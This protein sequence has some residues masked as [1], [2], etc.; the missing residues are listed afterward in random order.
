M[1]TSAI[2]ESLLVSSH[3]LVRIAA[4]STGSTTPSAIWRTLSILES[5]GPLRIGELARISRVTQ[6]GM[7]RLL[8]TMVEEELVLRIADV[9]DSRA[10]LI[11]ITPKGAE[12][13]ADWRS[14]LTGEL[15]TLFGELPES[16]WQALARAAEL[17][18]SRTAAVAVA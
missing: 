5:E 12:R 6:P 4:Q 1:N 15:E 3:R 7:T 18:D 16:D 13:L 2:L 8:S 11:R 10:W 14:T 9:D 17:L